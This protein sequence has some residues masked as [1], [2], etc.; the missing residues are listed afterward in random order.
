MEEKKAENG[1]DAYVQII[2][3]SNRKLI[4]LKLL[5]NF[6]NHAD[7]FA[8]LIRTK[9]IHNLF[10]GNKDLDINKLDL[11]HIQYTN[12]LIE[13][14][15]KLK[16]SKE[17]N[18]QLIS[19]EIY[20]NEDFIS[21]LKLD[22]ADFGFVN[23]VRV[24]NVNM[25]HQLEALYR[26]LES[27][28]TAPLSWNEVMS[29]SVKRGAEYYRDLTEEKFRR[30]TEH[31]DKKVYGGDSF[32]IERKLLGKLNIYHFSVKFLCGL[33]CGEQNA[34]IFEFLH[35][36][37]KFVFVHDSKSFY[38]LDSMNLEGIDISRNQS[39]KNQVLEQLQQKNE[40]LKEQLG[41][42]RSTLP[43]EVE[44]VLDSYLEKISGVDFLEELQSVDEQTN[45]LKAMLNIN[46]K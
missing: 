33:Q 2:S 9:V 3:E 12:T 28:N 8:V 10:E 5:A 31:A 45:I 30:L 38:L 29:F 18:Y 13:L 35:S 24:H 22:V 37:E 17:Q 44:N 40:A 42:I 43:L 36:S 27:D 20:I 15:Q 14:F 21:R 23:D 39:S 34:E 32:S 25:T 26:K 16:K 1:Q 4:T 7:L 41:K 46:I 19:D 11:F 6:F